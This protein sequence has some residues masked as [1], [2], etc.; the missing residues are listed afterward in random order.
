MTDPS[1]PPKRGIWH[2]HPPLPIPNSALFDWP[3]RPREALWWLTRRWVQLTSG[4]LFLLTAVIVWTWVQPSLGTMEE[5][6][7]GWIGGLW[8]RNL[9]LMTLFAGALHLWLFAF[10]MQGDRLKYDA[11]PLVTDNAAFT[12]RDQVR[13]NMFWTLA[14]GVTAWTA[15]EVLYWWGV[16]NEVIPTF[17]FRG[18]EIWFL[19]WLLLMP[20]WTSAHFYWVHRLLHWPPLYKRVHALHHRSINIGP[21]SGLSMHPVESVLYI[22]AVL[23]HFVV[24]S[25]PVIFL[26]HLYIKCIG[27]A[28]SHA[29]FESLLVRDGKLMNA[30]DFHHQLHHRYFECN[31]GTVE[32]P[33]DKWFGS[34][35]DGS[36]EATERI[37]E[38][39]K[40][41]YAK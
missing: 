2:H 30:G 8:L 31:Y 20:L 24:P 33:W 9:V 13:D 32:V 36:E 41:M 3:L 25:H 28:F 17:A 23:I 34:F 4:T 6:S 7:P 12:F 35:H 21:W 39:R 19:V 27:P 37:R 11:R 10:A 29:G 15:F 5:L 16:A 18:N 14:S 38:R 26:V 40:R 22:S 1:R